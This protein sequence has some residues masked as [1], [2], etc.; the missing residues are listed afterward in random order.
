MSAGTA[1]D[2]LWVFIE[3]AAQTRYIQKQLVPSIQPRQEQVG[4]S[5][6]TA[7]SLTQ[8][9]PYGPQQPERRLCQNCARLIA[10]EEVHQATH[11]IMGDSESRQIRKEEHL[12]TGLLQDLLTEVC[13][14]SCNASHVRCYKSKSRLHKAFCCPQS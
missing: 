10:G 13:K 7:P 5:R 12:P 14:D 6:L 11:G 2:V 9:P 1:G 8:P 3:A 4:L